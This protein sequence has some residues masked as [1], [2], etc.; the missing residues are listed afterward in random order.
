MGRKARQYD[1]VFKS[2]AIKL[3]LEDGYSAAE[4]GRNLGI[5]KRTLGGW[6]Q[7]AEE[8]KDNKESLKSTERE[9][10]KRLRKEVGKLK[11]ERDILKKA[12]AFFAVENP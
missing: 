12:V 4:A 2:D 8:N 7:K 1:D 6:L 11:T 3:V 5:P 10:L 9:E